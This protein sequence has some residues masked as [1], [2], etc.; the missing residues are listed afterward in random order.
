VAKVLPT[1]T[2]LGT[3][4]LMR[5]LGCQLATVVDGWGRL[6]GLVTEEELVAAWAAGPLAAV[7]ELVGQREAELLPPRHRRAPF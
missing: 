6:V 1:D 4:G 7:G 5:R 3:L 2:V